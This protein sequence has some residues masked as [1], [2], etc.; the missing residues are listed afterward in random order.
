MKENELDQPAN[1]EELASK[2]T[3]ESS[4]QPIIKINHKQ[5]GL[6]TRPF[7]T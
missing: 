5:Q 6:F 1:S 2:R 4:I 7:K 3:F